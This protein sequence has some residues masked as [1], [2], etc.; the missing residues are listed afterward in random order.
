MSFVG[1]FPRG[2]R[3]QRKK[4]EVVWWKLERE[5][6]DAMG[7]WLTTQTLKNSTAIHPQYQRTEYLFSDVWVNLYRIIYRL[8]AYVYIAQLPPSYQHHPSLAY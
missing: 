7:L 4:E 1:L 8:N 6:Y 2:E 3:K 5:G